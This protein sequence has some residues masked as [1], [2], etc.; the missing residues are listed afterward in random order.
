MI[1][2][3]IQC[4]TP[5]EALRSV[6]EMKWNLKSQRNLSNE[7]QSGALVFGDE[8]VVICEE[9][10]ILSDNKNNVSYICTQNGTKGLWKPESADYVP[11]CLGVLFSII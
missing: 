6:K 11:A 7:R 1:S 5:S 4:E 9:G 8:I 2:L 3:A 10:Y